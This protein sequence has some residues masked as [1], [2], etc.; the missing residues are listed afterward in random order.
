MRK[1]LKN[2]VSHPLKIGAALG[3]IAIYFIFIGY[4]H[5]DDKAYLYGVGSIF[6]N[7]SSDDLDF[8]VGMN[9]IFEN[10][11][12][13]NLFVFVIAITLATFYFV[14]S[15]KTTDKTKRSIKGVFSYIII[16]FCSIC[17]IHVG[18]KDALIHKSELESVIKIIKTWISNRSAT[19]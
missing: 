18:L 13:F 19:V 8:I 4:A 16:L 9:T 2:T 7:N 10:A 3:L 11:L 15:F 14:D 5:I 1:T 12:A 6:T 17:F